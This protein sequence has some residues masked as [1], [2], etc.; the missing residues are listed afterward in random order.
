MRMEV[1]AEASVRGS[2]KDR[3]LN[4]KQRRCGAHGDVNEKVWSR[5]WRMD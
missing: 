2:V 3:S 4:V 5:P 1:G